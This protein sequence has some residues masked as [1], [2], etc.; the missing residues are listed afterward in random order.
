MAKAEAL[1]IAEAQDEDQEEIYVKHDEDEWEHA[2]RYSLGL[3]FGIVELGGDPFE[4]T[5][6]YYSAAFRIRVGR[7]QLSSGPENNR[8]QGHVEPEIG[9]WEA[10]SE[11]GSAS[12][13][14]LGVNWVGVLPLGA[15]DFFVG[16]GVG[17]HFV[18]QDIRSGDTDISDSEEKL[19][20]NLHFGFEREIS[21][22]LGL[23]GVG[24]V[25]SIEDRDALEIKLYGGV[26]IYFKDR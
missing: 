20:F 14:M 24:R 16:S 11:R 9:Y 21:R 26:R 25:D 17:V 23:F 13:M 3:G 4:N 15:V 19:G 7:A 1:A 5:E 6:P 12:D 22:S 18:D 8:M 2:R 10:D